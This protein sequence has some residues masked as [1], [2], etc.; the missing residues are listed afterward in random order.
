V[1]AIVR[2]QSDM[3][4]AY[5]SVA[6]LSRRGRTFCLQ[7]QNSCNLKKE[8]VNFIKILTTAWRLIPVASSLFI[9]IC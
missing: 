7:F 4:C 2:I 9:R 3:K 5:T 6:I 8:A 1:A